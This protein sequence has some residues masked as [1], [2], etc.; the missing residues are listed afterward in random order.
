MLIFRGRITS[1]G[2]D[3]GNS[4]VIGDWVESP[5]GDFTNIMWSKP[6]GTRILL[7]PSQKHA[8]FV[9]SLYSFDEVSIVDF[10][11]RRG[12]RGIKVFTDKLSISVYW[13]FRFLIPVPR[14]LWFISSVE[15]FFGKMIF[16]SSTYG[17]ARDGSR[18]WYSIRGFSR[19]ISAEA[20]LSKQNLGMMTYTDFPEKFGFSSPPRIPSSIEVHSHIDRD[21]V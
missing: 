4:I 12:K 9:S 17:R 7:S 3:C 21:K 6:D 11:T 8:D 20:K 5:L 1:V 19:V 16:G 15:N 14:P 2:F 13:G 10:D 18:E